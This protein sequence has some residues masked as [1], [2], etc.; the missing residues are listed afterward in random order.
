MSAYNYKSDAQMRKVSQDFAASSK[1]TRYCMEM[2][3]CMRQHANQEV[4]VN[5]HDRNVTL[6]EAKYFEQF[7]ETEEHL[8]DMIV[9][10]AHREFIWLSLLED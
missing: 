4:A 6:C 1:M 10:K 5:Q 7:N 3:F 9:S 8:T 2:Y